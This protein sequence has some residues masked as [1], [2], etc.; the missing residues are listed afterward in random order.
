MG[1]LIVKSRRLLRPVLRKTHGRK[2]LRVGMR[3]EKRPP[4]FID[5][6]DIYVEFNVGDHVSDLFGFSQKCSV[7]QK[8]AGPEKTR[9][10]DR[11]VSFQGQI[12]NHADSNRL[13]RVDMSAEI[14]SDVNNL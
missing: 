13:F 2:E 11:L 4:K 8:H 12:R 5:K 10:P 6:F 7:P 9:I 3:N 14:S 1:R